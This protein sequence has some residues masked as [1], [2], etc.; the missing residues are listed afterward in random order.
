M[1]NLPK[2]EDKQLV[3][4]SKRIALYYSAQLNFSDMFKLNV[5]GNSVCKLKLIMAIYRLKCKKRK[6]PMPHA[7]NLK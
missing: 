6:V 4:T 1:K 5:R 3:T 7:L 2:K